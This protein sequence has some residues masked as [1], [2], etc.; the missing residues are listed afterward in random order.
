MNDGYTLDRPQSLSCPDCGGTL[1]THKVGG[2]RQY[3]CHIGHVFS[4]EVLLAA[5]F[6]RLEERLGGALAS[7]N[8][9]A[10]LCRR[11]ADAA[12]KD[13]R[14]ATSFQAAAA[15]CLERAQ[16]LRHLLQS[17]WTRLHM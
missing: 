17:E 14:D 10:E 11:M 1:S 16:T 12:S 13:G 9:R 8:E 5:Q 15:E 4:T 2:F 7:L 6:A 3:Q